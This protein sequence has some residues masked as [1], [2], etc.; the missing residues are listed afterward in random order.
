[1]DFFGTVQQQQQHRISVKYTN[2]HTHSG[3]FINSKNGGFYA[4]K[5]V[6]CTARD[7][8]LFLSLS[9]CIFLVH[10]IAIVVRCSCFDFHNYHLNCVDL[11]FSLSRALFLSLPSRRF[12]L[13]LSPPVCISEYALVFSRHGQIDLIENND[14]SKNNIADDNVNKWNRIELLSRGNASEQAS[15]KGHR[16]RAR[17]ENKYGILHEL[18]KY[19]CIIH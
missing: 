13:S 5:W 18:N 19:M 2:T 12:S 9:R 1:M 16:K 15:A 7:L 14:N 3:T 17:R 4:S 10:I 6:F 11:S 8:S